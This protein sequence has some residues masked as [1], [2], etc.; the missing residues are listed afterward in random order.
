MKNSNNELATY[1]QFE[2]FGINER[3][4]MIHFWELY[5]E[6]LPE[7][8]LLNTLCKELNWFL[9]LGDAT[10][11]NKKLD[12]YIEQWKKEEVLKDGNDIP[13][14]IQHFISFISKKILW[15][16]QYIRRLQ[17]PKVQ[18]IIL[19]MGVSIEDLFRK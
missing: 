9:L 2:E 12:S 13:L 4:L 10:G 1:I 11:A 15:L 18:K 19:N 16:E 17:E 14:W 7:W 3:E 8:E 6:N 5:I